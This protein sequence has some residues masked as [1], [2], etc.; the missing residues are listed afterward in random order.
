MAS[1]TIADCWKQI[2]SWLSAN[3]PEAALSLPPGAS[4]AAFAQAEQVLGYALPGEVKEFLAIHDGSAGIWLHDRGVF[5]SLSEILSA[6][7]QEFD[8]WGDGNN[9]E[10]A[11]PAGPIQ[12]K[13]FARMWLP[14]LNQWTGDYVCIDLDP[15]KGGQPGQLFQWNHDGGPISVIE[16]S[17]TDLLSEF[18]T[19]LR[20][21]LYV[22]KPNR[23]GKP[24]LEY[25]RNEG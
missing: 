24:Y 16:S 3:T 2:E 13:W 11:T 12:K 8:L 5:M 7:D 18:V 19:E 23:V 14:I 15:P 4:P 6:W 1:A 9:D 25:L 17:L 20:N 22:P 10:W 21:G